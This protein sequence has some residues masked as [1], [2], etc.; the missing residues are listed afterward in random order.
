MCPKRPQSE[1]PPDP[2]RLQVSLGERIDPAAA[3]ALWRI[4]LGGVEADPG[5]GPSAEGA[6]TRRADRHPGDVGGI[7]EAGHSGWA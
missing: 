5:G 6:G 4:V 2:L 7:A 1:P 3:D